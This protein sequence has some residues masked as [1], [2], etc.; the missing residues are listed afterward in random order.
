MSASIDIRLN[1]QTKTYNEN[2]IIQGTVIISTPTSFKH[3]GITITV[4]GSV[5]LHLSGKSVGVFEAFYNS[6]K[7]VT[8]INQTIEL[9]KPGQM[10]SLKTEIPFQVQL[11]GRPNKPLYETYHGV[12]V[13]IQYFLRVDVKRTFLSKDMSK[14]I[15]F[16]IEY[17][18]E[19]DLAA[20]KAITKPAAF[21]VTSESIKTIQ[22]KIDVPKFKITG[23]LDSLCCVITKPFSGELV[24]EES[25]LPI[26]SI[27]VQLLRVETCGCAEGFSRDST[28]IQNI[29][30]GDGNV[31]R[32]IP[33]P[34]W[35][36][37][38]RTFTCP[39]LLTVN[40]KI[41][42]EISIVLVFEDDRMI[43]ENFP[44][45]LSRY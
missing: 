4:D 22:N 18:P 2:D 27:E 23:N 43:S 3:N 9:A 35:M 6:T 5:Q 17:G 40:F 45:R 39:T 34:I 16:N 7:P 10:P 25:E 1:R 29:Q 36:L 26:K 44:L 30:I 15:E 24:V 28:E 14:Q 41:E 13:N 42:F 31:A 32:K 19:H 38:P 33:V 37:F 20:E 21:E 12:F 11:K 8:L